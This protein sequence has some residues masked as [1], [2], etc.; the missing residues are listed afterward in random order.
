MTVPWQYSQN[1][2]IRGRFQIVV[3]K[4]GGHPEDITFFRGAPV[5]LQSYSNGDPFGDAACVFNLPQI[6]MMD[7]IQATDIGAWLADFAQVDIYWK[8]N[9]AGV[10]TEVNPLTNRNSAQVSTGVPA[11]GSADTHKIWEGFIANYN[12]V[13]EG[14]NSYLSVQCQGAL[15]QVD[16]YVQ[17]PFYPPRPWPLETLIADV[18]NIKK[19]PHLR[20]GLFKIEWPTGWTKTVPTYTGASNSYTIVGNPGDKYTGYASRQ[21]GSW[22]HALTGFVADQL[23]VMY[24]E[25]KSGV[26]PG[27]QW[28]V[29]QDVPRIPVLY[30]RD[31]FRTPDFEIWVGTPGTD[32]NVT[33]D[34]TQMAKAIYGEGVAP[35]GS[36]WRNA[37]IASDGS[38]TDYMPLA[39][40][41]EVYPLTGN[42]AL[43]KNR[44]FNTEAYINYGSGIGQDQ[45]T[46][47]A[48]KTL[49]RDIDAGW[50]GTLVFT[51]DPPGIN[52]FRM[53]AGMTVKAKGFMGTGEQGINF[54]ISEVDVDVQAGKVSCKI[55]SKYRDLLSL[56]EALQR[57]R[58][59]LTP[60]KALQVNRRSAMI[61][62][63]MAPWDYSAGS[64]FIPRGSLAFHRYRPSTT[65]FPWQSWAQAH[66]P[67][68][69]PG[70]YVRVKA[71]AALRKDRWTLG[72]AVPILTSEKG[73]IRR[74]EIACFDANGNVLKIAFHFSVYYTTVTWDAMP[75]DASGPSPFIV[76][77]FESLQPNGE[78]WPPGNFLAPDPY[79]IIGWG[80][81]DQPAG[82]SP[83]RK[84]EGFPATGLLVDDSTWSFDNTQNPNFNPLAKPGQKQPAS[85][86]LLYGAFYAEYTTPVYFMGRMYR[87]EPGT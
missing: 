17:K 33:H 64:G 58:D 43:N 84:S 36:I 76:G 69:Y 66:P 4:L 49:A 31:R 56:E 11:P 18:F 5:Q 78:P 41:P 9:I 61:E 79:M 32:L 74:T 24:T 52:R 59:P 72:A 60:V 65:I 2:V 57:T 37:I 29:R 23:T 44:A 39:Y 21:T 68:H 42:A 81:H 19:K 34:T 82:Y 14:K 27:N 80:N 77:A 40:V 25:E 13:S 45:A 67:V 7:D 71:N 70:Y 6:T 26:T 30:V 85:V 22:E 62:D 47:A 8:D 46:T 16:R 55:D 10:G 73:T 28:T 86:T 20:T 48:E 15:Y 3:T 38:R 87:Q 63:N 53:R 1:T 12:V 51:I 50:S 35:D 54:H 83:G 75:R